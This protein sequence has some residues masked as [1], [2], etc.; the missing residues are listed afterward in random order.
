MISDEFNKIGYSSAQTFSA[1]C[2]NRFVYFFQLTSTST[3]FIY[4]CPNLIDMRILFLNTYKDWGGDEKWTINIAKG[5]KERGH[6][7]VVACPPGL[8]TEKRAIEEG[9]MVFPFTAGPDI[10]FWK[11]PRLR[12]YLR[13]EKIDVGIFVQNRDVKVGALGAKMEGIK[14]ILGRHALAGLKKDRPYH[15]F[16]YTHYLDG[17]ITNSRALADHYLSFGWFSDD[18]MHPI[19]DGLVIPENVAKVDLKEEFGFPKDS[20]VMVGAGRLVHQKGFDYMIKVARLAKDQNL[21][22]RFVV[23]GKGQEEAKLKQMVANLDVSDYIKF[24]GFRKD[25]FPVM[26]AADLFILTSRSESM[27]HVLR[28][29]MS[30]KTACVAANVTGISELIEHEKNGFLVQPENEKAMFDGI[31]FVLEQPSL[32]KKIEENSLKRIQEAFTMDRM[33][34]NFEDLLVRLLAK[35]E[36]EIEKLPK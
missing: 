25:V 34:T 9:L 4:F 2:V 17:M 33:I 1:I 24:V 26:K 8:E 14:L 36:H 7:T 21:N 10:A 27:T 29:A 19:H 31:K 6:H 28:E 20:I 12:K 15:K 13:Q 5:L 23:I 16:A 3:F 22:W 30:V 35:K 11:I 32:K 18:F